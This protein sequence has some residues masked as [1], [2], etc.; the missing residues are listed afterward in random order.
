MG[1]RASLLGIASSGRVRG[2][3]TAGPD[4]LWNLRPADQ[5]AFSKA[6]DA[7]DFAA[8]DQAAFARYKTA[9]QRLANIR[10]RLVPALKARD[11]EEVDHLSKLGNAQRDK[12]TEVAIDLDTKNCGK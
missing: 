2:P 7:N 6:A 3:P 12:R 9:V 8:A 11:S 4:E 1:L 5:N 10:E